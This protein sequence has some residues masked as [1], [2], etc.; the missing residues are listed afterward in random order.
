MLD[1]FAYPVSGIM[2][3][4]HLLLHS[5]LGLDGS[6]AWVLS[7]VGLVITVRGLITPFFWFQYKSGRTM[8]LMMPEL[9]QINEDLG[10]RTDC[11]ARPSI[12]GA[13]GSSTTATTTSRW[14]AACR[15]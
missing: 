14:P 12:S 7:L 9:R 8:A 10:E 5:V 2:K 6:I 13:P 1:A 15:R 4:W 3:L 11:R